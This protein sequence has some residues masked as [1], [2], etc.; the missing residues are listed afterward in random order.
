MMKLDDIERICGETRARYESLRKSFPLIRMWINDGR[1]DDH[2][3]PAGAVCIGRIDYTD[4][5]KGSFPFKN[6]TPTEGVL[7]IRDDHY[8]AMFLKALPNDDAWK[9]NVLITVDFYGGKKRWSGLLDKWN[10][11]NR[12]GVRYFEMTFHDDLTFLQYLLCPPNPLLPI[13]IFQFP[14]VFLLAG[15]AKWC[16]STLILL[17]LIRKEGNLWQ[18]PDDPFDLSQ[19][20]QIFDWSNWQCLI[21]SPSFFEDGS[22]WTFMASRMNPVDSVMADALDDAQLSITYRRILTCDGEIGEVPGVPNVQNG[23]LVF[24]VVDMSNAY[25]EEGTAQAGNV[26]EGFFRSIVI[27]LQGFV[28]DTLNTTL[29]SEAFQP[30]EYY[31]NGW[32]GTVPAHPWLVIRD[33]E[34]TPIE[35]ADMSWGP[36]KNVSVIVGGDNPFVDAIARLTIEVIGNL[37]GYIFLLGFSSAGEIAADAIMPFLVGTILAW[38]EWK[39]TG[40]AQQLG[41]IHYLELYQQGAENNAWSFSA[42]AALRGGFLV[43][44]SETDHLMALHDFW[45]IPGVHFDVGNRIGS[46]VDSPGIEQIIFVNQV[47]EMTAAWDNSGDIVPYSWEIR[48]GKSHRNLSMGE[49]L[50]RLAKKF[51]EAMS[52]LGVSLIAG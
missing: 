30:D 14:R 19:W 9:K 3:I 24:E 4:T 47:E 42:L 46:T 26:F 52:N 33:N 45:A 41:W 16:I 39:N 10:I 12:D 1:G 32:L 28:E 37:L 29:D 44:K 49:R 6:N 48:A 50:A 34:W 21:R 31:S 11:R 20:F 38:L 13:P 18:V 8:I 40:R 43:G 25:G 51:K 5:I 23:C 36:S 15:P 35:S 2:N 22:L 27:Y 7:Q 17:N